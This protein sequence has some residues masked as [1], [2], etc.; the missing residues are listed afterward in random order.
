MENESLRLNEAQLQ[1]QVTQLQAELLAAQ[2]VTPNVDY[3]EIRDRIVKA[4]K[5]GKRA[6]SKERIQEAL[7]KFIKELQ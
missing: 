1:E 5:V 6:E 7:D 4:W 3:A 2:Q